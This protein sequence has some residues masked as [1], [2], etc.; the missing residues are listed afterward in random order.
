MGPLIK[1]NI[2]KTRKL[3]QTQRVIM[4]SVFIGQAIKRTEPKCRKLHS[5]TDKNNYVY[6]GIF[7]YSQIIKSLKLIRSFFL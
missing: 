7:G 6:I 1:L 4:A 2:H 5:E 3:F